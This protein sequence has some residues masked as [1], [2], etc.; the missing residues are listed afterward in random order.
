MTLNQNHMASAADSCV[1]HF[2]T[3]MTD[4]S[5]AG[6]LLWS[7]VYKHMLLDHVEFAQTSLVSPGADACKCIGK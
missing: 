5:L 3:N 1:P 2:P 4:A 6:K 7:N